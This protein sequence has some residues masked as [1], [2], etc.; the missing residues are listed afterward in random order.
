MSA[1]DICMFANCTLLPS[2]CTKIPVLQIMIFF[3]IKDKEELLQQIYKGMN[4]AHKLE[5]PAIVFLQNSLSKHCSQEQCTFAVFQN[6]QVLHIVEETL[7]AQHRGRE[8]W[9]A[10]K[11]SLD[12]E[13]CIQHIYGYIAV[14]EDLQQLDPDRKTVKWQVGFLVKCIY[15]PGLY[16]LLASER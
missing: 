15:R 3:G 6:Q 1:F 14:E 13:H 12:Q 9:N 2:S 10:V 4:R 8:D 5:T 11:V 16:G 7:K